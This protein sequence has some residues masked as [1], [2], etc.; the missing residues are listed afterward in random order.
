M[1]I[2]SA[3]CRSVVVDLSVAVVAFAAAVVGIIAVADSAAGDA[4]VDVVANVGSVAD[5]V[6]TVV[7]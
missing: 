3:I 5:M 1:A 2:L 7:I 4:I 6:G